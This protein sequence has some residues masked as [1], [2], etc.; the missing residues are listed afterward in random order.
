MYS[1]NNLRA[2]HVTDEHCGDEA[3]VLLSIQGRKSLSQWTSNEA[4]ALKAAF[5]FASR[6]HPDLI[7][8][9]MVKRLL[10]S[11]STRRC[12]HNTY[13]VLFRCWIIHFGAFKSIKANN[14]VIFKRVAAAVFCSV[15]GGVHVCLDITSSSARAYVHFINDARH[16]KDSLNTICNVCT[17]DL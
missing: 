5:I 4:E 7:H 11:L 14:I 13:Q 10:P 12:S 3:P 6:W 9:E 2:L 1:F 8:I 15:C 16:L 17:C